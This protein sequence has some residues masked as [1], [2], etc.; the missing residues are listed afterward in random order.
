MNIRINKAHD[1]GVAIT[2]YGL[3]ISCLQGVIERVLTP[4]PAA[5]EAYFEAVDEN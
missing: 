3:A 1:A 2:N 5:L 4:F